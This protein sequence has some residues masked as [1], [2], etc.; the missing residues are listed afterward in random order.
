MERFVKTLG[1]VCKAREEMDTTWGR[2]IEERREAFLKRWEYI[3]LTK[4]K[5]C[6]VSIKTN[7]T[8]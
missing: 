1:H 5:E 4:T 3:V 8:A 7:L 2:S 6:I